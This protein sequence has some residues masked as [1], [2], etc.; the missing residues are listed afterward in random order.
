MVSAEPGRGCNARDGRYH[1][2]G[3]RYIKTRP[4]RCGTSAIRS[5]LSLSCKP[6]L[7]TFLA[8]FNRTHRLRRSASMTAAV[9]SSV[10]AL[11]PIS[12]VSTLP[13]RRTFPVAVRIAAPA[14]E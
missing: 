1:A 12:P 11:P 2:G 10:V 7:T 5:L 14:P 6:G 13:D 8:T 4:K 3:L 9:I